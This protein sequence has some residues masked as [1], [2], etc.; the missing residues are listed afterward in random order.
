MIQQLFYPSHRGT[1]NSD[2]IL[3]TESGREMEDK[4]ILAIV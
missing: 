4:V 1:I 3:I 2:N